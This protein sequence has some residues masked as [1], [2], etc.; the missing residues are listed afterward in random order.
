M[1]PA[2]SRR[3]LNDIVMFCLSVFMNSLGWNIRRAYA[4]SNLRK[5]EPMHEPPNCAFV[6]SSVFFRVFHSSSAS[7]NLAP[8]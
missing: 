5:S 3:A 1:V 7:S 6:S 2:W 8:R 4:A